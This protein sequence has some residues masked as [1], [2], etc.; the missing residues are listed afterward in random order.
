[1]LILYLTAATIPFSALSVIAPAPQRPYRRLLYS[2]LTVVSLCLG[3]LAAL[4]VAQVK[5]PAF[6]VLM[7]PVV[8]GGSLVIWLLRFRGREDDYFTDEAP[9]ASD[10][11]EPIDWGGFDRARR[12][13]KGKPLIKR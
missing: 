9:P 6:V 4:L 1:M 10:D 7:I 2:A 8:A 5:E 3:F 12:H 11:S 13:W